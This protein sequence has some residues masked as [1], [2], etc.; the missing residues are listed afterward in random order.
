[1]QVV[2]EGAYIETLHRFIQRAVDSGRGLDERDGDG[3][4]A[5]HWAA[6]NGFQVRH[7]FVLP[8][9]SAPARPCEL[10]VRFPV[11]DISLRIRT[12][13]QRCW[14][15]VLTPTAHASTCGKPRSTWQQ[16]TPSPAACFC[17][18][19]QAFFGAAENP[20]TVGYAGWGRSESV[21]ELLQRGA[22]PSRADKFGKN[23]F[24]AAMAAG[25][26][27]GQMHELM[28]QAAVS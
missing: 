1:M 4:T 3:R 23:A 18:R 10:M 11:R 21:K 8:A 9:S 14:M 5:L 17:R 7:R 12:R 2:N 28:Q 15:P 25:D 26:T 20:L 27:S 24:D 13:W 22:D 19:R 6:A 16:V